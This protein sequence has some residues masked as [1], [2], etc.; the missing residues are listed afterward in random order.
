VRR[1]SLL[2]VLAVVLVGLIALG[3]ASG[4]SAQDGTPP[5]GLAGHPLV[6]S[7]IVN[8]PQGQPSVTAFT[9]DGVV[10]DAE[11]GG[12]T[13]IGSWQATGE[14][15]AAFTFVIQASDAAQH[16]TGTIVIR[17]TAEVDA[18]GDTF[19]APYSYTVVQEDGTVLDSGTGTVTG[20]RLP[21]EPVDKKGSPLAGYPTVV[22]SPEASPAA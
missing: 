16:F 4:S 1:F 9:A 20:T 12:G 17:G 7:W 13:G 14:R 15:T 2:A 3:R 10:V 5:A 8:D 11:T 18:S 19:T 22:P 21:I 6:G